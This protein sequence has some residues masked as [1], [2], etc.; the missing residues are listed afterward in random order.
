MNI[1]GAPPNPTAKTTPDT[2]RALLRERFPEA[3]TPG[4]GAGRRRFETGCRELDAAGLASGMVVEV[5]QSRSGAGGAL[6]VTRVVEGCAAR[7][8]PLALIDGRDSFDPSEVAPQALERLLWIRARTAAESIKA[9]D[10]LLRDGNLPLVLMDLSPLALGELARVPDSAWRR[11][12]SLAGD[13]ARIL[14]AITPRPTLPAAHLRLLL[15]PRFSLGDLD[16]PRAELPLSLHPHPSTATGG[17]S[18]EWA[19]SA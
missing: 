17:H 10:L 14:L 18:H 2:L 12:R 13:G 1:I 11:L 19:R 5:T 6:L 9:A 15:S 16:H 4:R 7:S 8:L 3:H